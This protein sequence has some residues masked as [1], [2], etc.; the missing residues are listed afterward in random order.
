MAAAITLKQRTPKGTTTARALRAQLQIPGVLYGDHIESR[1]FSIPLGE[2][3]KL[4]TAGGKTG[5]IDIQIEG[6]DKL[7]KAIVQDIQTDP[8]SGKLEHIDLYQVRM[9]RKLHTDLHLVFIGESVAVKDLGGVLVKQHTELP[10]ECLPGDLVSSIDVS[11]EPIKT[12]EDVIRV[13]DVTLPA[14]IVSSLSQDEIIAAVSEP[15]SEEDLKAELSSEIKEGE[16]EV[17]TEKKKEEES[18]SEGAGASASGADA[19]AKKE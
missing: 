9:D 10:I 11:I 15:R 5:L 18:S 12:F 4:R 14:G 2:A 13:K 19:S 16:P 3:A 17:L 1:H 7:A 8:I 6:E